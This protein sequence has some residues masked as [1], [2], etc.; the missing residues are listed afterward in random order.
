[1]KKVL[2]FTIALAFAIVQAHSQ[3]SAVS[4]PVSVDTQ[5]P[6]VELISPNGGEIFNTSQPVSIT[7][8]AYDENAT[9]LP[10]KIGF[11]TEAG[12][13]VSWL[14]EDFP[15]TGTAEVMPPP[16]STTEALVHI[17][18]ID[19]FGNSTI[20][21]SED[22]FTLADCEPPTAFAG[23]NTTICQNEPYTTNQ[24]QAGNGES[25]Q[26]FTG[27]TGYFDDPTVLITTYY[28]SAGDY[29]Q[30]CIELFLIV[31]A[32]WPCP[33]AV[34][35]TMQLCFQNTPLATAGPDATI[36]SNNSHQ[37]NGS[38][39]NYESLL[40]STSGDGIFSD[41]TIP[42]PVYTPGTGDIAAGSAQLTL[43]AEPLA[44]C[45][46][47]D[48]DM[49]T[50]QIQPAPLIH[51]I[52]GPENVCAGDAFTVVAICSN[53]ANLSWQVIGG[54]GYVMSSGLTP[55]GHHYIN[56]YTGFGPS[57][58]VTFKANG[59]GFSPCAM[60]MQQ[61]TVNIGQYPQVNAG[62]NAAVCQGQSHQ[63]NATATNYETLLWSTSGDGIFSDP[64]ILNPLYTP[65]AQDIINGSANLSL[66]A[67]SPYGCIGWDNMTLQIKYPPFVNA[68]E[69]QLVCGIDP[70]QLNADALNY[71]S[72][73]WS[74][75]GDGVFSDP[76]ITNPLYSP[77]ENDVMY[78][79]VS[80]TLTAWPIAPCPE[81]GVDALALFIQPLPVAFAGEHATATGNAPYLL[82]DA[83]AG[84]YDY[85]LWQSAGDGS[86]D[87]PGLVNATY[88]PGPEDLLGGSV[89]LTLSAY[90][91]SPCSNATQHTMVLFFENLVANVTA[92]QRTDGSKLVDIYFD[93]N[94]TEPILNIKAE[95][96]FDG[97]QTFQQLAFLSGDAGNNV[98][99]GN[100]KHI[101]WNAGLEMPDITNSQSIFRITASN[102][103]G[104]ATLTGQVTNAIDGSPVE[105]ALVSIAGMSAL[106][107][108]S[109]VY[110]IYNIPPTLL[111]AAF[112]AD[113]T[114]GRA[115]LVVQFFNQSGIHPHILTCFKAGLQNYS[116]S[117][118]Y[119]EPN[120]TINI[121]ISLLPIIFEFK[122]EWGATPL[123]MDSHLQTPEISGQTYHVYYA[124][125][126]NATSPPFAT[127][128]QDVMS[129]YG[130]EII[131]IYNLFEGVYNYYV[132]NW[133]GT[134][135][136]TA[137]QGV[138]T[139][140][141]QTGILHTVHVPTT[142]S[143]RYWHVCDVDGA[144]GNVTIINT[145]M[146]SPPGGA[147][148]N[149]PKKTPMQRSGLSWN[150]DFGDGTQ[151]I[152]Q[153]PVKIFQTPGSYTVSL[154]VNLD[155]NYAWETK[156]DFITVFNYTECPA[157]VSDIEGNV[158]NT[159][160]I[161]NQCWMKENLKTTK[162]RNGTN[163][164][165]PTDNSAWQNNTT[166]AYVWYNNNISN[167]DI[168]GALYNWHAV[169]NSAGLC[170]TG[171]HVPTDAEW[172][173][174]TTYVSSQ[175]AYL[176]NSNT[177]YIAKAMAGKTN[178]YGST[179]TCAV[180]NN[181]N[182]NN[183]TNFTGLPGGYRNT[184]GAF[185][186]IG[187]YGDWWSSTETNAGTAWYRNLNYGNGTVGRYYDYKAYGFS[188][189]CLRD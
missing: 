64:S 8:Q 97:M 45:P 60:V 39:T 47:G 73:L 107:N 181:L 111:E 102:S 63:L 115:P 145:I 61:K 81:P 55:E 132:H 103:Q 137:S 136:I 141:G 93:L 142:G 62:T 150:W 125:R 164:A 133:S 20:E 29:A 131:S 59:Y 11:S 167:K 68:G 84:N 77:G 10:I 15:N 6:D 56:Y 182:A 172:T 140:Y 121:D 163:I 114:E 5:N 12:G 41:P 178:W 90:P 34:T 116:N 117:A 66:E 9:A 118:V 48:F 120:E 4:A 149:L 152:E 92:A 162:Y 67:L 186:G 126:G 180:G 113:R 124:N 101:I 3:N 2:I 23:D 53:V 151:S 32:A 33:G 49:M 112:T 175:P 31:S 174:L 58:S 21:Q 57:A 74:T 158:Y 70:I 99:P 185:Y 129:G 100:D 40:W 22:F 52:T 176:C 24:A 170:P 183:A 130:P 104:L 51:E 88:T 96:S 38:A 98:I 17:K 30:G 160:L 159:V 155:E 156:D 143:G 87:N 153:N 37:L 188:V 79:V 44:P 78:G 95:V 80:I 50:L 72:L 26:W 161:D 65:G 89:S 35:S 76:A 75:S 36:C 71:S 128:D 18:M 177:I 69:D 154:A 134:P 42:N 168:Y 85:T 187:Y 7:W 46:I 86:F 144:T 1:M 171:W 166:G 108:S 16:V 94:Y 169:N 82:H 139:I 157:T 184:N 27:G 106:T 127:L 83:W 123:I 105:G 43:S 110:V 25:L 122:L 14:E 148:E 13:A 119:F 109:G 147:K 189:R 91:I 179:N 138:V 165:N 146:E 54:N 28:P 135:A 19:N 173:A